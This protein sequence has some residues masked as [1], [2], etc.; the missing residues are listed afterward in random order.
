MERLVIGAQGL[1]QAQIV[2]DH[3]EIAAQ[4]CGG[5]DDFPEPLFRTSFIHRER[6]PPAGRVP[7]ALQRHRRRADAIPPPRN[8]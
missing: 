1:R 4:P 5:F 3:R 7:D 2:P 8:L 6:W